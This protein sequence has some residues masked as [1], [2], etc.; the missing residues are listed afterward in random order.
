MIGVEVARHT[1]TK[2]AGTREI[3]PYRKTGPSGTGVHDITR[4]GMIAIA[5]RTVRRRRVR[6]SLGTWFD[7]QVCSRGTYL[8]SVS[9]LECRDVSPRRP[10]SE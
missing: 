8:F 5:E 4:I 6:R 7:S 9:G 3:E 10:L 2:V 1:R